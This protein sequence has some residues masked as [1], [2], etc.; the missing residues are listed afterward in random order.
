MFGMRFDID[1]HYGLTKKLNPLLEVLDKYG[2]KATFFCVMG[3]DAN[4]Y[5][6]FK[7]RILARKKTIKSNAM[8]PSGASLPPNLPKII[9]TLSFPRYVGHTHPNILQK[10][11]DSGHEVYPHGWSHIQWQRNIDNINLREH[12]DRCTESYYKI[13]GK[14]PIGFGSPGRVYNET[15]LRLFDEYGFLFV[16]DMDGEKPFRV[17]PFNSIQIPVTL[18]KTIAQLRSENLDCDAIVDRYFQHIIGNYF[19]VIYEHPDNLDAFELMVLSKLFEKLTCNGIRS[20]TFGEIYD[21]VSG[22]C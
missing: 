16:G 5:E 7:L 19:S 1:C 8:N 13:F 18:F 22:D 14:Y 21:A 20:M 15:A 3:R 10:L 2:I 9:H 11:V 17:T 12:L 4:L 6:I